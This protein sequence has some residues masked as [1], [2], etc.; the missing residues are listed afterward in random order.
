M[1]EYVA[2]TNSN[3]WKYYKRNI[4]GREKKLTVE[5]AVKKREKKIRWKA[6][7]KKR[8]TYKREI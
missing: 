8:N 6:E 2:N 7:A 4:E 3:T 1:Q 5:R